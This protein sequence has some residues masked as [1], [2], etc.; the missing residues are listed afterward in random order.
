MIKKKIQEASKMFNK[1]RQ[2]NTEFI[3][4]SLPNLQGKYGKEKAEKIIKTIFANST[5]TTNIK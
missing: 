3:K 5:D 2:D 1:I 4:S